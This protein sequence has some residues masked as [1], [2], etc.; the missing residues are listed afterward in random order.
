[1]VRRAENSGGPAVPANTGLGL[2]KGRYVF[3]L[4]ADDY[5]GPEALERMV[6]AADTYG[7]DVLA[8]RMVGVNGRYVPTELFTENRESVTLFDSELPYALSNTKLFRR[9]LIEVHSLRYQEDL[10]VGSDQP[11]T[12]EAC[13]RAERISVLADYDYYFAVRRRDEKNV[14][15]RTN[16]LDR[17]RCTER[18]MSLTATM[19]P[20]AA[21][22]GVIAR[23]HFSFEL[24]RLVRED[25]LTLDR[26]V[27]ELVC[28]GIGR[29]AAE[30]LTEEIA[31]NLDAGRR[32]RFR[33]AEQGRLDD[34]LRVIAQDNGPEQAPIVVEGEDLFVAY[35]CFRTDP[36]L[37][38]RWFRLTASGVETVAAQIEVSAT[39]WGRV[40][41]RTALIVEA[42][43]PVDLGRFATGQVG[44]TLG[45]AAADVTLAPP[46]KGA[47]TLVRAVFP[48]SRLTDGALA[49]GERRIAA[50]QVEV[51]GVRGEFPLRM[52]ASVPVTKHAV[53]HAGRPTRLSVRRNREGVLVIDYVPVT[54]H[55]VVGRARRV[56]GRGK[57]R[58]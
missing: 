46:A 19:V 14:T 30:H 20:V 25:L 7:S 32:V 55:R 22:R 24:A 34:L 29:L 3:F 50:V 17:L 1:V 33:L 18:I 4:G 27:Q 44:L 54:M 15:V 39:R 35:H 56:I 40:R 11:F 12:L 53:W 49:L 9:E 42:R 37:P 48:L 41:G 10:A 38:D 5:L 8:A 52:P 13:L 16:H 26:S 51:N 58:S 6:V 21:D 43:S 31:D 47:G 45:S 57:K 23:R 36:A 28:A 2:A